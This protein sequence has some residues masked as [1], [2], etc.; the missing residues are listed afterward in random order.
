MKRWSRL[1]GCRPA[2]PSRRACCRLPWHQRRSRRGELDE[3]GRRVLVAAGQVVGHAHGVAAAADEGGLDEVVAEDEPAE[4]RLAG[5]LGQAAAL[6]EGRGADDGVVAPVVAGV[7]EPGAQAA[8]QDRAV[9][10][11][12][13]LLDAGERRGAADQLR[14]GLQ[15]AERLVGLHAAGELDDAVGLHQAVGV[16]HQHEGIGAAPAL[17]PVGDVAGLAAQVARRG[18]GRRCGGRSSGSAR[19]ASTS[20]CSSSQ[21]SARVVSLSRKRSKAS[22]AP[23]ACEVAHHGAGGAEDAARDPRCRWA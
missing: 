19:A 4:R 22:P 14:R 20:A 2:V 11:A 17:D 5:Q 15:D 7:A 23:W 16:E 12:G 3:V 21:T 18:G 1:S 6:G 10:A 9:D 8:G 13:E